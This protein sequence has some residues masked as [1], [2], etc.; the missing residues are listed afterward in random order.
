MTPHPEIGAKDD[1]DELCTDHQR[2]DDAGLP[3]RPT[4]ASTP[5]RTVRV[6]GRDGTPSMRAERQART[7]RG[8]RHEQ[9]A[10]A[11]A[12]GIRPAS[13]VDHSPSRPSRLLEQ[14][15]PAN[16]GQRGQTGCQSGA[17]L[18]NVGGW[19]C[20]TAEAHHGV[21]DCRD[22]ADQVCHKRYGD[23]HRCCQRRDDDEAHRG[24][25]HVRDGKPREPVAPDNTP[26][27][28]W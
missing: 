22:L 13:L 8:N 17:H 9:I 28:I 14:G 20:D 4:G 12:R 27:V 26:L 11:R 19:S 15:D 23:A 16:H 18:V 7:R 1:G 25:D 6:P 10:E 2:S 21:R 24:V 3:A 5:T